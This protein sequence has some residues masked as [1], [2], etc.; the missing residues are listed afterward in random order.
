MTQPETGKDLRPRMALTFGLTGH[1]PDRLPAQSDGVL[2]ADIEALLHRCRADLGAFAKESAWYRNDL[3]LIRVVSAFAE[4]ADWI[5]AKA[6]IAAEVELA[7]ALPFAKEEYREDF[8]TP[9]LKE[10]FDKLLSHATSVL[11]LPGQRA[12]EAAAYEAAGLATLAHADMLIALWDGGPSRGR[13]GTA[14][15]VDHAIRQ[16]IPVIHFD[17]TGQSPPALLWAG[18]DTV[19][20]EAPTI[21]TVPRHGLE[22]L[23]NV[24]ERLVTP[25]VQGGDARNYADFEIDMIRPTRLGDWYRGFVWLFRATPHRARA[26]SAEPLET[27]ASF[28]SDVSASEPFGRRLMAEMEPLAAR[29]DALASQ[30]ASMHR[31]GTVLNFACSALAVMLALIGIMAPGWKLGLLIG[32]I[33]LIGLILQTTR[34]ATKHRW[35]G[36]W[37][38]YRHLAERVRV[39]MLTSWMG[40]PMLRD[41]DDFNSGIPGWVNWRTRAASRMV[42]PPSDR[43]DEVDLA[44]RKRSMSKLVDEQLGYHVRNAEQME[45]LDHRTHRLGTGVFMATL[46]FCL[47]LLV[48]KLGFS[49]ESHLAHD[50]SLFATLASAVLPAFGAA[51]FGIRIQSDFGGLARRSHRMAS[52]LEGLR[53]ALD[54]DSS[55]YAIL[56]DRARRLAQIMV[57][58]LSTWRITYQGRP[59]V[60]PA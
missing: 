19:S 33:L 14:E 49:Q 1:R 47:M 40:Q 51:I 52:Q 45:R 39:L 29:A 37:L 18:F 5:A 55:D 10:H 25:P 15:M 16:N 56:L 59:L 42:G 44:T 38:D 31:G 8:A 28:R 6:A 11:E 13:G 17:T 30:F 53:S 7:A 4:G 41:L 57:S 12:Q 9:D 43:I 24:L 26:Q 3:P 35:H 21:W 34:R 2:E 23:S 58:D 32:E 27:D 22:M 36:K 46:A 54:T 48:F 60:L 50:I 20:R